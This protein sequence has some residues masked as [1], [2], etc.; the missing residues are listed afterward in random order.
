VLDN[1]SPR[2]PLLWGYAWSAAFFALGAANLVVALACGLEAWTWFA[3]SVPVTVKLALFLTQYAHLRHAVA[4]AL[5]TRTLA[6]AQ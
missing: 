6:P 2:T 4:V 5:K 3:A 1:L